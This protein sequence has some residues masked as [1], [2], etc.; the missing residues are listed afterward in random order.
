MCQTNGATRG[1][2]IAHTSPKLRGSLGQRLHVKST[3]RID[4]L[5]IHHHLWGHL[6]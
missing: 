1:K 6:G 4:L 3:V 5:L 2:R